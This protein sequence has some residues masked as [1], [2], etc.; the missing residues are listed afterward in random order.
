[1]K[2][3]VEVGTRS[4][5]AR[6]LLVGASIAAFG[7]CEDPAKNKAK[8]VT[9]EARTESSASTA[10]EGESYRFDQ[11]GS[12]VGWLGSKVTG[13]HEG[14]FA[15]FR[16]DV[17]VVDGAAEK[18]SVTVDID[19]GSITSDA[20]KLTGHLKSAD[21]LDVERFP[22]ATFAS[23]TVK[24]GGERGATHTITGNL[25]LHGVT[26]AITF[27]ATVRI[28]RD[29]V[30]IDSEFAINRKDFAINY[31]GKQDDLIRD[32]VV[33]KLSIHAKRPS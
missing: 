17:R 21:F 10:G 11:A 33:I 26:K 19:A 1:M 25:T 22:K 9:G 32:E 24:A 15:T 14:A 31:P 3:S 30:S 27:P 18:S 5:T 20:E 6:M 13:K 8:A 29:E 12:M 4:R 23:T 2:V 7:A 16:G 28:A